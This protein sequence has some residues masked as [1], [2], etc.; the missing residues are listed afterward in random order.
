MEKPESDNFCILPWIHMHTWANGATYPCCLAKSNMPVGNTNNKSFEELWN[1]KRMRQLRLNIINDKPSTICQRCYE[2][3]ASGKESM[4][5]AM[6]REFKHKID[7]VKLTHEDGSLD[8]VHMA[9]LDIRYSNICNMRCRTCGPEFSSL[10]H[11]DAVKMGTYDP[12]KPRILK[13]KKSID[14]MWNDMETWINTVEQ[15]YFA[16]GEP[17]IMEEHYKIL[18]H[19][20]KIDKT[21]IKILYN[22]N[23]SKLTYKDKDVVELWKHFPNV[24]VGASLDA[25][26]KRAEVLR[27]GTVWEEIEANRQRLIDEVPHVKFQLSS[28]ISIF[29]A[30]HVIDFWQNWIDKGYVEPHAIDVNILLEAQHHRAE[31]LP[32]HLKR[33]VQS[34]IDEHIKKYN[35]KEID[36]YGRGYAGLISFRNTLDKDKTHL[37]PEFV[38]WT[39]RLDKASNEDL[40]GTF[41]ELEE[42][43]RNTP[44]KV[45]IVST[46][47]SGS[48]YIGGV[49][50]NTACAHHEW[51]AEPFADITPDEIDS[52]KTEWEKVIS[53]VENNDRVII[54]VH[55]FHLDLLR[56]AGLLDRFKSIKFDK[57][58]AIYRE[59]VIESAM[60]LC[61]S[62][63]T[64]DWHTDSHGKNDI[65]IS[66]KDMLESVEF[67][68]ASNDEVINDVFDMKYDVLVK[69]EDLAYDVL[70]DAKALGFDYNGDVVGEFLTKKFRPKSDVIK[71]Y[72]EIMD[73][74][75]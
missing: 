53:H 23:F 52:V 21:D 12:K 74:F 17:L 33:W 65:V 50:K 6:T 22:T 15:I 11:P 56:R 51:M 36:E 31:V 24:K 14:D 46:P 71:N 38:K 73:W 10:W 62:N 29:N 16:G 66:K 32:A 26:W 60:S 19:L 2:H 28:T 8:D 67:F 43:R 5:M 18:E 4:R 7:R 40:Y 69:Y 63:K 61:I 41:I 58:L 25:M 54:K 64:N 30:M 68:T 9:Y 55:T 39:E 37:I 44:S 57:T 1:S 47:R 75:K 42:V 49:L 70:K 20:I 59:D 45:L 3:E 34:R 35:I 48:T 27:K 13:I 72:D